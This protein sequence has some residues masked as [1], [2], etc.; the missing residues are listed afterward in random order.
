MKFR[1]R[2]RHILQVTALAVGGV[3]VALTMIEF[4]LL[5]SYLGYHGL[6]EATPVFQHDPELGWRFRSGTMGSARNNEKLAGILGELDIPFADLSNLPEFRQRYLS[7]EYRLH[8]DGHWNAAG[9]RAASLVLGEMLQKQIAARQ[10]AP[11]PIR[12]VTPARVSA[13]EDKK[14]ARRTS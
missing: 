8:F 9:H 1:Q 2:I 6:I 10:A 7:G 14:H 4:M 3:L 5:R 13:A 12:A 11:R